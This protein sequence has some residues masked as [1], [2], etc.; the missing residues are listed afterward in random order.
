MKSIKFLVSTM[1]FVFSFNL[2]AQSYEPETL[3]SELEYQAEKINNEDAE[4]EGPNPVG[5]T[6]N[7]EIERQEESILPSAEDANWSLGEELP[8]EDYE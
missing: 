3:D 7:L 5:P 6:E 2:L 8:E 4:Y 1:L